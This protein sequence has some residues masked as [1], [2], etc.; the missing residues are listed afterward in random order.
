[1]SQATK[2]LIAIKAVPLTTANEK[3]ELSEIANHLKNSILGTPKPMT[4]EILLQTADISRLSKIYKFAGDGRPSPVMVE[5]HGSN[6]KGY[7]H[8]ERP[9][10][11]LM[12][13]KGS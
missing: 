11:G 12:A 1:V 4:N 2:A 10:L 6:A 9:A 5:D 8:L 13:I 7:E 3:D